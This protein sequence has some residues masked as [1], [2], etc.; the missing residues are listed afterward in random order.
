MTADGL[1]VNKFTPN[2]FTPNT[3]G[4]GGPLFCRSTT[5][6]QV[7]IAAWLSTP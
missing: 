1:L 3:F 2:K 6:C 5:G 4:A 7:N